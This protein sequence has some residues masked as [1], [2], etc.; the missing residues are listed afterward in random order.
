MDTSHHRSK[1]KCQTGSFSRLQFVFHH[2]PFSARNPFPIHQIRVWI[3]GS[4]G[5]K[6]SLSANQE[7]KTNVL[8]LLFEAIIPDKLSDDRVTATRHCPALGRDLRDRHDAVSPPPQHS[9]HHPHSSLVTP[10][11]RHRLPAP[12]WSFPPP[13]CV[14]CVAMVRTN[15]AG[16]VALVDAHVHLRLH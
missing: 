7:Q 13:V 5:V 4:R 16:W 8:P 9:K 2:F 15:S 6:V 14:L 11:A 3:G 1:R 12:A 10:S